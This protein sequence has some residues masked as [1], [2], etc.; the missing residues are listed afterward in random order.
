MA[1]GTK[2]DNA[3]KAGALCGGESLG[4]CGDGLFARVVSA[5]SGDLIVTQ[6]CGLK[7]EAEPCVVGANANRP[8]QAAGFR[9][10]SS[11]P[12]GEPVGQYPQFLSV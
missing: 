9:P 1:F 3:K 8:F 11:F 12:N 2:N 4:K 7:R 5:G 10:D 6:E